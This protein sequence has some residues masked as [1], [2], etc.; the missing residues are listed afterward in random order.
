[1]KSA[2]LFGLRPNCCWPAPG[3][4]AVLGQAF[5]RL[6]APHGAQQAGHLWGRCLSVLRPRFLLEVDKLRSDSWLSMEKTSHQN[7]PPLE[8]PCSLEESSETPLQ[9]SHAPGQSPYF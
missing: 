3:I 4:P 1:M 6:E 2:T 7:L 9:L 5:Q 8:K